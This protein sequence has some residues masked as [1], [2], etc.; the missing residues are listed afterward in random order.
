MAIAGGV[1]TDRNTGSR[2]EPLTHLHPNIAVIRNGL[3]ITGIR[4]R[5]VLVATISLPLSGL[6]HL[7]S[8][9]LKP[10]RMQSH[11][12]LQGTPRRWEALGL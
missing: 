12:E 11:D 3:L 5:S 4:G 10:C 9:F 1:V 7:S 6:A 8:L 2:G